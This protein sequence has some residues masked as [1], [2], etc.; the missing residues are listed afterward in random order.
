MIYQPKNI[1]PSNNNAVDINFPV[2]I[3]MQ[4]STNS[5][6]NGYSFSLYN[7][8]DDLVYSIPETKFSDGTFEG[9]DY[10]SETQPTWIQPKVE[11]SYNFD[12]S[13]LT[14]VP[15]FYIY[16]QG[17]TDSDQKTG[18]MTVNDS[19]TYTYTYTF[20][21]ITPPQDD[22]PYVFSLGS[23]TQEIDLTSGEE[24][25]VSC[26]L[27]A[28]LDIGTWYDPGTIR[29]TFRFTPYD[30]L[31]NND[32]FNLKISFPLDYLLA[33]GA[34]YYW[35]MRFYSDIY[36]MEET[37][38]Y[39]QAVLSEHPEILVL[40]TGL[41]INV[42]SHIWCNGEEREIL[43]Y[44]PVTGYLTME[45][46]FDYLVTNGRY[47]TINKNYLD[48][49]PRQTLKA[50]ENPYVT[51]NI[52][53]PPPDPFYPSSFNTRS[54]KFRGEYV[55]S[56]H[57]PI[58]WHQWKVSLYDV[59][60]DIAEL[61]YDTGKVYSSNLD[62]EYDT[63]RPLKT[64]KIELITE[65]EF[66]QV[67][68]SFAFV[69]MSYM[70]ISYEEKPI[71][72]LVCEKDAIQVNWNAQASFPGGKFNSSCVLEE[73][74]DDIPLIYNT[75]YN[76]TNSLD[77][78]D[79]NIGYQ[80]DKDVQFGIATM[81]ENE[82]I[83]AQF[84]LDQNFFSDGGG[85]YKSFSPLMMFPTM[86]DTST[87]FN[88]ENLLGSIF[89]FID[90]KYLGV[91]KTIPYEYD[92]DRALFYACWG[93]EPVNGYYTKIRISMPLEEAQANPYGVFHIWHLDHDCESECYFV[94]KLLE[95]TYD[96]E[97]HD[98]VA[99]LSIPIPIKG[100][101][102]YSYYPINTRLQPFYTGVTDEFVL[103]NTTSVSSNADYRWIDNNNE[104]VDTKYWVEGGGA[105]ARLLNNWWKVEITPTNIKIER[106]GV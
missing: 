42:G 3:S 77:T 22:T 78:G 87:V 11:W 72:N 20:G 71:A 57:I 39:V 33:N 96:S 27:P 93:A 17:F 7:G 55:Q 101:L 75:P 105:P 47:Y 56:Q 30:L 40:E 59:H 84:K 66:N 37:N 44:D 41:N 62:F 86:T 70:P 13:E 28:V 45:S 97:L 4:V 16:G 5:H 1:Q 53:T 23:V 18:T 29:V 95:M 58:V 26:V 89:L 2:N 34:D 94:N 60:N 49:L 35:T 65:N 102:D 79:N 83:T 9:S 38:G 100:N 15:K 85:H 98:V 80:N 36:D 46:A 43:G 103:Q 52:L 32:V 6:I 8:E 73:G 61:L 51:V 91:G 104:W 90:D 76:G 82:R 67:R 48:L 12:T 21:T 74:I 54:I 88:T 24:V 31:Y 92:T 69:N 50:R 19:Q 99:T 25:T 106:G 10:I 63:F 68:D 81:P 14:M 64:Y